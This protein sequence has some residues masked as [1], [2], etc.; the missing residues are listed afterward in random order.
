M[1]RE[2]KDQDLDD[3]LSI[4]IAAS[5][6][7]H[8]FLSEEFLTSEKENIANVYLPNAETWVYEADGCVVGFVSL[9][10]NEIGGL[11]VHPSH[12]RK[13]IGRG[14]IDQA[15]SL[16][17]DLDLE[18]FKAN[19]L[20]LSFYAKCGFKPIEEKIHKPTGFEVIHLRLSES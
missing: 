7:A 2:Y 1:I 11:F 8:P 18:V 5:Q 6:I 20:G 16:R 4:W 9:L 3:L 19:Q 13:G 15:R 12:Q 14:L 10:G 17:G